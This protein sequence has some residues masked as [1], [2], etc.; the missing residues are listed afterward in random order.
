MGWAFFFLFVVLKVPVVAAFW[1]IWWAVRAEPVVTDDGS[2]DG[3]GGGRCPRHRRG[4]WPRPPAPRRG[5]HAAASPQ[6]PRRVRVLHARALA[7]R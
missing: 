6:P 1:L 7:R 3:G 4:R 5:P 2:T